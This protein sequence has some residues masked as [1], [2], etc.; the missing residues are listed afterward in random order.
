MRAFPFIADKLLPSY[1]RVSLEEAQW[2][3]IPPERGEWK[4]SALAGVSL[5]AAF[6]LF[7][8]SVGEVNRA[9]LAGFLLY[10]RLTDLHEEQ[11]PR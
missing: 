6:P 7:N 9:G 3:Q 4:L 2:P 11:A 1:S 5:S 10:N 8:I